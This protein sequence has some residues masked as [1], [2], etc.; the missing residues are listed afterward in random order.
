[1]LLLP[2]LRVLSISAFLLSLCLSIA[3]LRSRL[4]HCRVRCLRF[5]CNKFL[6]GL[7]FAY[8]DVRRECEDYTPTWESLCKDLNP[9]VNPFISVGGEEGQ[10]KGTTTSDC[11]GFLDSEDR[12]PTVTFPVG[13]WQIERREPNSETAI[14]TKKESCGK[15]SL[16]TNGGR[17]WARSWLVRL[18]ARCEFSFLFAQ[19]T[20]KFVP[21]L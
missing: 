1:V 20:S 7:R 21:D 2:F 8:W 11:K 9:V 15:T 4:H 16:C 14:L 19:I 6:L 5:R 17:Q 18:S 3:G 13:C 10:N 12:A